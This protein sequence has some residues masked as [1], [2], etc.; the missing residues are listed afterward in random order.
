MINRLHLKTFFIW[1]V[2]LLSQ[3]IY[4][5]TISQDDSGIWVTGR[6]SEGQ[7]GTDA[8]GTQAT[9]LLKIND[10][11]TYVAAGEHQ[12]YFITKDG[13]LWSSGAND[14]GQLGDGTTETRSQPVEVVNGLN[15]VKVS[16]GRNHGLFIKEDGSLWGVGRNDYGQLG[17]DTENDQAE[18]K[19]IATDVID[20]AGGEF[21]T[22]FLKSDHTLWGVGRN[23][24]GQLGDG[25]T[26]DRMEPVQIDDDVMKVSA[27][28]QHS[29][30]IKNDGTLWAMGDNAHGKLGIGDDSGTTAFIS[31]PAQVDNGDNVSFA[32]LKAENSYFVKNDGSLWSVGKNE[33]GQL[34]D[35]T[36]TDRD[37][38]VQVKNGSNVIAVAAG[39][40]YGVFVRQD[41]TMWA[42]GDTQKGQL[43]FDGSDEQKLPIWAF[44]LYKGDTHVHSVY[45]WSHGSHRSGG[46]YS[47]LTEGWDPPPGTGSGE[48]EFPSILEPKGIVNQDYYSKNTGPP[49]FQFNTAKNNNYDFA[50]STDHSQENPFQP[51]DSENEYWEDTREAVRNYNDD[52][53]FVGMTGIEFSRNSD[54]NNT[55]QGHLNPIN[56]HDYRNAMGDDNTS[57]PELYEWLKTARPLDDVGHIAMS[58]NHPGRTQYNDWAH[59]DDEIVDIVTM[60]E[61]RTVFRSSPR[62]TAYY[63]SLN[64]GWKTSPTSVHDSHGYW[65]IGQK[66]PLTNLY[67]LELT[68]EAITRAM[69]QRRTFTSW[70]EDDHTE[71][72]L[73]YSV[74]DYFMGSTL[75]SPD[76]F[77]FHIEIKTQPTRI[78]QR[79]KKIQILRDHPNGDLDEVQVVAEKEFDGQ[80]ANIVWKPTVEDATAKYF[81][82]QVFHYS[83]MTNNFTEYNPI[84][85]TFSAPIWTGR[86]SKGNGIH[87]I[88]YEVNS[89][90]TPIKVA[91][92]V[93]NV[94][95]GSGHTIALKT[96]A[97]VTSIEDDDSSS[98]QPQEAILHQNYPNPFNPVTQ[99]EYILPNAEHVSL[100]VFNM[101]GQK[102]ATLVDEQQ[103]AGLHSATFDAS[104]L[105]SGM[106]LYRIQA[107]S[108]LETRKMMLVK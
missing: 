22:L 51:V 35:G 108:F 54:P 100:E 61:L 89:I 80:S 5:Q 107:G 17:D 20:A 45:S 86:G 65:N 73:R 24:L 36:K 78:F 2:L 98:D 87:K 8:I 103:N 25:S 53:S 97:T 41:S 85:S 62:L 21:H 105:S 52:P 93:E 42:M 46:N 37:S 40:N 11:A 14:Y 56:I 16:A 101:L 70:A 30:Y 39:E 50:V 71:V 13:K 72:D 83:D 18:A 28:W 33:H 57:I 74:N 23:N 26:T 55:G 6:N 31:T 34:G 1:S 77:D 27:G 91:T 82:L 66:I 90:S 95:A 10:E 38:P 92:H 12:T 94:A 88:T 44:N 106:Y 63:R 69:R 102:V 75:D 59:W 104:G 58:F 64:K 43:A 49:A 60:F 4:A 96:D 67:A 84:G 9:T 15:V 81:L 48:Q 19:Q 79:V 47:E 76:I 7:L 68:R 32:S 99:L 3:S 29:Y